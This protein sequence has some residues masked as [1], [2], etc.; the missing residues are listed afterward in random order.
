MKEKIVSFWAWILVWVLLCFWYNYFF[1][2]TASQFWWRNGVMTE[3]RLQS[4]ADRL[5]MTKEELQKELDAGKTTRQLMQEK[6]V[7]FGWG[8][9]SSGSTRTM[10][11]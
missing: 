2:K 4:T 10:N 1:I 3:E 9:W 6:W 7:N 8:K 5:W 11:Q